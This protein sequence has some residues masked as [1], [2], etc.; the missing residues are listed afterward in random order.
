MK[1]GHFGENWAIIWWQALL[2]SGYPLTTIYMQSGMG[3]VIAVTPRVRMSLVVLDRY[4]SEPIDHRGLGRAKLDPFGAV[5]L[6]LFVE[7][8]R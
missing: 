7:L 3:A 5:E 2:S 4:V 6:N 8:F 1:P